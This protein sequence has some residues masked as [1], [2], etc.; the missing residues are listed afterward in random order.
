M[1][2]A[3]RRRGV[4]AM[5]RGP[6]IDDYVTDGVVL[7]YD[8]IENTR[9][10]H[11][12]K[13]S[14]WHD[15]SGGG[16]DY[17]YNSKNVVSSLCCEFNGRGGV[18]VGGG[19]G[20]AFAGNCKFVEIVIDIRNANVAQTVMSIGNIAGTTYIKSSSVCFFGNKNS[21]SVPALDG[22]HYYNSLLYRDNAI[23]PHSTA[24]D[25]FTHATF[26]NAGHLFCYNNATDYPLYGR[27]YAFRVHN[28]ILTDDE[29][30]NNYLVDKVR[31]GIK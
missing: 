25:S 16:R 15:L 12:S 27:L 29:I 6:T 2:M 1:S 11:N 17:P 18:V 10:G 31:F 24:A 23:V 13:S 30:L 9:S 7:W 20:T 5:S 19:P 22:V 8:G 3:A 4:L 26:L 14:Y 28:R 21:R